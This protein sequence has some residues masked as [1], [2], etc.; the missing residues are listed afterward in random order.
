MLDVVR[1]RRP[2]PGRASCVSV[3]ESASCYHLRMGY[4]DKFREGMESPTDETTI[5]SNRDFEIE[6]D[7]DHTDSE[8]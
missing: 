2:Q 3:H 7:L 8:Y 5:G 1:R 4:D 6:G